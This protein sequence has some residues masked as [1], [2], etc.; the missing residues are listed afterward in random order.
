MDDFQDASI[1]KITLFRYS[2]EYPCLLGTLFYTAICA[3]A[4]QISL[5][6]R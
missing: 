2:R 3:G 1:D 6:G 4:S 5:D